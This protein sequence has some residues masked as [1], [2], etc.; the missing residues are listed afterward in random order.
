MKGDKMK[1]SKKAELQHVYLK[2]ISMGDIC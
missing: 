2:V 1:L